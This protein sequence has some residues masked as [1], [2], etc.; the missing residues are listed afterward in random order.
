VNTLIATLARLAV[1][2]R[3]IFQPMASRYRFRKVVHCPDFDEPAEILV[4][5]SSGFRFRLKKQALSIRDCSLW[6]KGKGCTQRC[7]K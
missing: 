2:R 6:P 5:R 7:E 3:Q 1:G 4:D